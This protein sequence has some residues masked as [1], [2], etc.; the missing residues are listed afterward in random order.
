MNRQFEGEAEAAVVVHE[1]R[2]ASVSLFGEFSLHLC[3]KFDLSQRHSVD[4]DALPRLGCDKDLMRSHG[5]SAAPWD[6]GHR[7]KET[8]SALGWL[9]FCQLLGDFPIEGNLL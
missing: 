4:G 2:G 1:D 8:S 6:P 3:I 9:D 5:F 7:A